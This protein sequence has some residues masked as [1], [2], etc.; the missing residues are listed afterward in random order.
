[1]LNVRPELAEL[2][3][4][5][6]VVSA[7][8]LPAL[9]SQ[10]IEDAVARELKQEKIRVRATAT[11]TL[12]VLI[13][14]QRNPACPDQAAVQVNVSFSQNVRLRRGRR[15]VDHEAVFAQEHDAFIDTTVSAAGRSQQSVVA[16]V[17]SMCESSRYA[18]STLRR[19]K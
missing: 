6:L 15:T 1:M 2:S 5:T 4:V 12:F 18:T 19:K 16:L 10:A 8:N 7:Q 14:Y 9:D 11:I 17:H 3:E 13:E